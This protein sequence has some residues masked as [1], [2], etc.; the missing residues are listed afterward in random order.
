MKSLARALQTMGEPVP[1]PY[2]L[3]ADLR[4]GD[5]VMLLAAP[6]VGKSTIAVDWALRVAGRGLPVT[7]L[8]TDTKITEQSVRV[9][10]NLSGETK[11][12]VK[13]R[14]DYWGGWLTGVGYPLR[15]AAGGFNSS[16][17]WELLE[18]EREFFGR[19]PEMLVVDVSLDLLNGEENAGNVRK[20]FRALHALGSKTGTLI[21]ALHHVKAGDA[22]NGNTFVAA[23]DGLYQVHQ[24]PET[25][26]TAW[27][28]SPGRVSLH[29]A[30]NRSGMDGQTIDLPIDFDRA[31][32]IV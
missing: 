5:L 28:P 25:V 8:T 32:V 21:L 22:A 7:Y 27:R 13:D 19:Y 12:A 31:R 4:R 30:K 26:L 20:V 18:A 3:P 14:L 17:V 15:W 11:T 16:N 9:I 2:H 10:A 1:F 29:L 6:K 23:T 24:I